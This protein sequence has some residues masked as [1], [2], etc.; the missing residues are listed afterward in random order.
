MDFLADARALAEEQMVD[1]CT[2]ANHAGE[3]T[4]ADGNVVQTYDAPVYT[5][6][7]KVQTRDVDPQNPEAGDRAY[8][9]LRS[10]VDVP[11]SATGIKKNARVTI[12]SSVYDPDLVGRNFRVVAPFHKSFASARR[13]PVEES[14]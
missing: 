13:L 10:R 9:V 6:K 11:M 1:S 8:T 3:T 14:E 2:I 12:T 7:C 5:G 4:D